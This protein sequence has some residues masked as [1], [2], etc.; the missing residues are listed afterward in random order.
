MAKMKPY[1]HTP[2]VE[3]S[4][5]D[6]VSRGDPHS[7]FTKRQLQRAAEVKTL[8]L[9]LRGISDSQLRFMLSNNRI[10]GCNLTP[11][12]VDVARTHFGNPDLQGKLTEA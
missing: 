9:S 3:N 11:Q 7:I 10:E 1:D 12:D 6:A 2:L 5:M 4:F 8:K